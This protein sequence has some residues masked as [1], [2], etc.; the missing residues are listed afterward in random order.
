MHRIIHSLLR[1]SVAR[2]SMIFTRGI[3]FWLVKWIILYFNI[4]INSASCQLQEQH[5]LICPIFLTHRSKNYCCNRH[6]HKYLISYS[7]EKVYAKNKLIINYV[8]IKLL[9][10]FISQLNNNYTVHFP[11]LL[12]CSDNIIFI[13]SW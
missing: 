1:P 5:T 13:Q 12:L 6:L 4:M 9:L 7:M 3:E 2:S 10:G 11:S 8:L